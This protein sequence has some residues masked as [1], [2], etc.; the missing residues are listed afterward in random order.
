MK[1][2]LKLCWLW[3]FLTTLPNLTLTVKLADDNKSSETKLCKSIE[4]AIVEVKDELVEIEKEISE[5]K[6]KG[7]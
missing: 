4:S 1:N 5:I 6:A 2:S 7:L 3:Y